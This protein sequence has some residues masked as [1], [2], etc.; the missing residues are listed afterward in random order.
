MDDGMIGMG[1]L[2]FTQGL[3][4]QNICSYPSFRKTKFSMFYIT[5]NPAPQNSAPKLL[6]QVVFQCENFTG[7][8]NSQILP[9]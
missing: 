9:D 3:F 5:T 2:A 1:R 8:P 7:T 6:Y 4:W